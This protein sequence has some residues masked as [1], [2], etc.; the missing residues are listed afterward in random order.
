VYNYRPRASLNIGLPREAVHWQF[1]EMEF[2]EMKRNT[3]NWSNFGMLS[4]RAGLTA[5]AALS[6]FPIDHHQEMVYGK[7]NGHVTLRDQGRDPNI[8]WARCLEIGWIQ[9]QTLIMK[10]HLRYQIGLA[11][12]NMAIGV[13]NTCLAQPTSVEN[14]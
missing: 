14:T 13:D 11:F 1:G 9:I 5:S 3:S 2:G 7:S 8:H 12:V 4:R 10:W 6:C